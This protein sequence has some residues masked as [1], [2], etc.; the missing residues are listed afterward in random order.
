MKEH[1]R[2][3]KVEAVIALLVTSDTR[4]HETDE[5]GKRAIQILQEAGHVIAEYRIVG[6]QETDIQEAVK[7]FLSD[8][9]VQ[10]IITSGGTGIGIKDKTVDS[11]KPLLDKSVE[12]FGE[13]FRRLSY[14]EIGRPALISRSFA[15]VANRKLVF[16]LPGSKS[17]VELGIKEIIIPIL[18]HML[19]ELSRK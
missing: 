3:Q 10:V 18:G 1:R 4:N 16:C 17:A 8:S 5:T 14:E 7:G 15:G 13:L 12:G 6:N 19:W 11:V 2:D 9:R